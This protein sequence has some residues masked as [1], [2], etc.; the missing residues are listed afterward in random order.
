M[1]AIRFRPASALFASLL[2]CALVCPAAAG[3]PLRDAPIIWEADDRREAPKPEERDPNL[4][5]DGIDEPVVHPRGRLLNPSR[6]I[7]KVGPL[8][9]SD[10]VAPA[11]NLNSLDEVPNSAWFTNRIGIQTVT[12]EAAARGPV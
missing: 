5:R 9:G 8:F 3:E 2:A 4:L 10:H 11:S 1:A 6:L 7:R 12:P